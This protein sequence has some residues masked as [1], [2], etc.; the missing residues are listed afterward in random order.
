[1]RKRGEMTD[2]LVLDQIVGKPGLGVAD[3][4]KKL[5]WTNGRV[6]GSIGRLA[7]EGKISVKHVLKRGA[8]IKRV[9][10]ARYDIKMQ[11]RLEVSKEMIKC[12]SW[13]D[14]ALVYALSRSTIGVSSRA[15]KEWDEK[16]L[17]K[18]C[19]RVEKNDK[20]IVIVLPDR[21]SDFYHLGNSDISLSTTDDFLLVTVE[22]VLPVEFSPLHGEEIAAPEVHFE[23]EEA[24]MVISFGNPGVSSFGE[25]Q[26]VGLYRRR[27][28][29]KVRDRNSGNYYDWRRHQE[30][31][32]RKKDSQE[33]VAEVIKVPP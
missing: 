32:I 17:L 21:V 9:Y 31:N 8:L 5:R 20:G 7:S 23:E 10:P 4:A 2:Q 25:F 1:M 11:N 22:S 30:G 16:A 29:F 26:S 19:V 24:F 33:P 28:E 3:I 6:D 18:D 15:L 13:R 27:G 14:T 12:D